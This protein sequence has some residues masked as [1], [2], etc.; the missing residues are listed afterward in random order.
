MTWYVSSSWYK[1][2]TTSFLAV[3]AEGAKVGLELN[4]G[5]CKIL[6]PPDAPEPPRTG[7]FALPKGIKVV[8]DGLRLGGA[9]IGTDEFVLRY[10]KEEVRLV[11]NKLLALKR[12][13]PQFA[14]RLLR[15]TCVPRPLPQET[16]HQGEEGNCS[17][18]QEDGADLGAPS[19]PWPPSNIWMASGS[20]Y[21]SSS[22][23]SAPRTESWARDHPPGGGAHSVVS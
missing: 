9:P 17:S 10:C 23:W 19:W 4:F 1:T 13:K 6:L 3:A 14:V 2:C 21:P 16:D 7:K 12:I 8:R 18:S 20:S 5:K 15:R 22:L 11:H